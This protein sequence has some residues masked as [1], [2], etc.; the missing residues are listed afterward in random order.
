MLRKTYNLQ[1]MMIIDWDVHH[2]NGAED[3]FYDDPEGLF[4]C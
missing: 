2:G 1:R 4:I 3:A